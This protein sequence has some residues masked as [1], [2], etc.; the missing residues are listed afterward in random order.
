MFDFRIITEWVRLFSSILIIHRTK[1]TAFQIIFHE[2]RHTY[3]WTCSRETSGLIF[4]IHRQMIKNIYFDNKYLKA[5][6]PITYNWI[7]NF[8]HIHY[9]YKDICMRIYSLYV[10]Y[11]FVCELCLANSSLAAIEENTV[12][13]KSL[14]NI[15][16]QTEEFF[17]S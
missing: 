10:G 1:R 16:L 8:I 6:S 13:Y 17:I 15:S 14:N 11:L 4:T 2:F 9:I 12:C 3:I 5:K 7:K